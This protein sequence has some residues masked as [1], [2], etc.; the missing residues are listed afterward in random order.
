MKILMSFLFTLFLFLIISAPIQAGNRDMIENR[1]DELDKLNKEAV[2]Q[3]A[4]QPGSGIINI[5]VRAIPGKD[6]YRFEAID[7]EKTSAIEHTALTQ[8]SNDK[9]FT[10]REGMARLAKGESLIAPYRNYDNEGEYI[11]FRDAIIRLNRNR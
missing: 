5:K 1:L 10:F 7:K 8:E 11:S 4:G 3:T 9:Y 6:G 2:K